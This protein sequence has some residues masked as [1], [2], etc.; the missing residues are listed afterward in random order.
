MYSIKI[1]WKKN[2]EKICENVERKIIWKMVSFDDMALVELLN[3][4]Q[5]TTGDRNPIYWLSFM[6]MHQ[7]DEN[8]ITDSVSITLI[9]FIWF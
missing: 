4:A 9:H 6:S 7:S 8:V 2:E 5:I 3:M 1:E